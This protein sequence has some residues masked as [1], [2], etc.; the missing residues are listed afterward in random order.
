M[1]GEWVVPAPV[2]LPFQAIIGHKGESGQRFESTIVALRF[3]YL[4]GM[5][6][7]DMH[8]GEIHPKTVT[9]IRA[10]RMNRG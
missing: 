10:W 1:T 3:D 4:G 7:I 8:G 9:F 2:L 5:T 6:Y